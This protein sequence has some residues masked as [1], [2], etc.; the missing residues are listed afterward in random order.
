[1][2]GRPLRNMQLNSL[3]PSAGTRPARKTP[4]KTVVFMPEVDVRVA[5]ISTNRFIA[6]INVMDVACPNRI[7]AKQ[8]QFQDQLRRP[9]SRFMGQVL[10]N[11]TR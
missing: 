7:S 1:M 2:C 9:K 8:D 10:M 6:E 4:N 5:C 11:H 3:P